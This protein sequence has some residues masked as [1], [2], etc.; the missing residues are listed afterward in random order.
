MCRTEGTTP[1]KEGP[2]TIYILLF[3]DTTCKFLHDRKRR[4]TQD[5]DSCC[6]LSFGCR[7]KSMVRFVGCSRRRG[8]AVL[9]QSI[10]Q[11]QFRMHSVVWSACNSFEFRLKT[12]KLRRSI[13]KKPG[14]EMRV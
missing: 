14:C 12:Q 10:H 3:G 5:S 13:V 4:A 7:R 6:L 11:E 2:G 1:N 9:R 8:K